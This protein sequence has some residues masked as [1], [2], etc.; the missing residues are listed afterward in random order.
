MCE[1]A[2]TG[3]QYTPKICA[4]PENMAGHNE[5]M[6]HVASARPVHSKMET[7]DRQSSVAGGNIHELS[8]SSKSSAAESTLVLMDGLTG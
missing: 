7:P 2:L 8:C 3:P 4:W 5:W 1:H 6:C